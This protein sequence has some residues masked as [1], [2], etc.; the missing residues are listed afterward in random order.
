[1]RMFYGSHILF[2]SQRNINY[3]VIYSSGVKYAHFVMVINFNQTVNNNGR[4]NISNGPHLFAGE[5]A[6]LENEEEK[7]LE[8]TNA[9][10]KTVSR[11]RKVV[12]IYSVETSYFWLPHRSV[13]RVT[14]IRSPPPHPSLFPLPP[15][16]FK[17]RQTLRCVTPAQF[18]PSKLHDAFL[19]IRLSEFSLK[20][21][22]DY[23]RSIVMFPVK[24]SGAHTFA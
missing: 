23:S 19:A 3:Y 16:L 17:A 2:N 20:S 13:I 15:L 21:A 5:N 8:S 6:H 1:M 22:Y 11:N 4:L 7:K 10:G 12:F 18:M 9:D 24:P 14:A